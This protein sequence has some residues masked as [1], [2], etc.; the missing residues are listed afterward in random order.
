MYTLYADV[1]VIGGGPGGF[2]TSF[3]ASDLGKKVILVDR[4]PTLGGICI[5][6]GAIPAKILLD[7]VKTT[8]QVKQFA[9][10]GFNFNGFDLDLERLLSHQEEI[11]KKLRNNLLATAKQK[12]IELLS[13]NAKFI[14]PK[15]VEITN[16][17]KKII[18]TFENAVIANGS[19]S[20][21]PSFLPTDERIID[22]R[23]ALKLDR[24]GG[25]LL[26]LGGG[27][28]GLEMAN[29]YSAIGSKVTVVESGGQLLPG[30]D[31]DLVKPLQE[32]LQHSC[33][34][35]LLNTK[36]KDVKPKEEGIWVTLESN[37]VAVETRRFDEILVCVGR[38]GNGKN[39]DP[40]KAGIKVNEKGVIEVDEKLRTNVNN[41]F[42]VGDV[43]GNPMLAHKAVF[44][45]RLVAEIIAGQS[46]STHNRQ[47]PCV[48]YTDPEIA[49][50]GISEFNARMR[51][52]CHGVGFCAWSNN[53]RSIISDRT[54]GITKLIF[55]Q[56]TKRII[57]AGIVGPFAEELIGELILAIQV[58]VKAKELAAIIRPYPSFSESIKIAAENFLDN[59]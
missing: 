47:I 38:N 29:I 42:A 16:E 1:L 27:V 53:D 11:I 3:R 51:G 18:V 43:N 24:V 54:E 4:A 52:I 33:S 48:V 7:A 31:K 21:H 59:N 57:G 34:K 22:F 46:G 25:E 15:Q 30:I 8:D 58:G 28:I 23:S 50:V 36:I 45:G 35:I 20:Y 10:R 14:S 40:E 12:E 32:K 49:V 6:Q 26:I 13:G 5:N 37:N 2:E 41:I 56:D 17:Q 44:E 9:L 19:Y 39:L 55:D